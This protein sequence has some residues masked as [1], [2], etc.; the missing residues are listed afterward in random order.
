MDFHLPPLD[1]AF[2]QKHNICK[3]FMKCYAG[4]FVFLCFA[5]SYPSH[6]DV[7]SPP[8]KVGVIIPLTGDWATWGARIKDGLELFKRDKKNDLAIE[9][10]Y[11]DEGTCDPRMAVSAYRYLHDH[12]HADVYIQGCMNGTRAIAPIARKDGAL[13]LSAGFQQSEVFQEHFFLV[14]LALQVDSEARALAHAIAATKIRKLGIVRTQGVDEFVRGMA[15]EF[16]SGGTTISKDNVVDTNETEFTSIL[17]KY[18]SPAVDGIFLN[19]GEFQLSASLKKIRELQLS[20]PIFTSYGT[21]VLVSN[22][23]DLLV[24]AENVSYTHPAKSPG[25]K[26]FE[27]RFLKEMGIAPSINSLFVYDGLTLLSEAVDACAGWSNHEC[28][29]KTIANGKLRSG[30]AGEYKILPDGSIERRFELR[31]IINSKVVT[32][33]PAL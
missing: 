8:L 20:V 14:N 26:E 28:L 17:T 22:N 29:F 3:S 33:N 4:I 27:A 31:Q 24:L 21:D 16:A 6:A 25:A 2:V 13:I 1:K 30:L 12:E 19:L 7:T 32:V 5:F 23:R 11:Q 9:F 18:R 10:S 15:E